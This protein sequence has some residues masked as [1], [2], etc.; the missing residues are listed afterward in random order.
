MHEAVF[1]ILIRSH[2]RFEMIFKDAAF[3][4][5]WCHVDV[6]SLSIGNN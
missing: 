2:P 5:F 6:S 4:T 3:V 1:S